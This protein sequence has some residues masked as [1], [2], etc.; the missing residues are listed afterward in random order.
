MAFAGH[1]FQRIRVEINHPIAPA[2]GGFRLAGVQL[3]GVHGDDRVDRS[4]V[5]A[6][7]IAKT[8]GAE[9]DRADTKGFMGV[10]FKGVAGDMG[11][12]QLNAGQL[13]Q[14]AKARAVSFITELFWYAL[15]AITPDGHPCI[16]EDGP[17]GCYKN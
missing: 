4:H 10:R 5:L 15:H 12:V 8:L 2:V 17:P 16:I 9:L 6:A 13:R 7:P 1:L 3:I 11:M 14:M